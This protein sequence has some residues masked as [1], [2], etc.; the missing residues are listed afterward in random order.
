M[1]PR[2]ATTVAVHAPRLSQGKTGMMSPGNAAK[3][4]A[5]TATAED[6]QGSPAAFLTDG[7]AADERS[8]RALPTQNPVAANRAVRSSRV[9]SDQRPDWLAPVERNGHNVNTVGSRTAPPLAVEKELPLPAESF[10]ENNVSQ[11]VERIAVSVRGNQ[12]EARI[13]L[14]PEHLGHIRLQIA[15]ENN[16]VSIRIMTE[17]PMARDLLEGHLHQLKMELQQQGL[18]VEEFNVTLSEEQQHFRREERRP[19]GNTQA[20]DS[21][22]NSA[23]SD[24]RAKEETEAS[25]RNLQSPQ[26]AGVDYFA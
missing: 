17:F 7:E 12:S 13:A 14:K 5:E 3:A 8:L 22:G 2:P 1:N 9:G 23:D 6:R 25:R 26:S 18:D 20:R 16:T 24:R 21:S 4:Q 11:I 19:Q 15:T 10:R